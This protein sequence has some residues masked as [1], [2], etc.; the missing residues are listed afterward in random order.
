MP[1]RQSFVIEMVGREDI[2][3]AVALN[4]AIFNAARI[5]GPAV[6]GVAIGIFD[7]GVAFLINGLSFLAVLASLMAMRPAEL[8]PS[9]RVALPA[10]FTPSWPTWPKDSAMSATRRWSCWRSAWSGWCRRPG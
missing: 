6:A 3:N 1:T 5:V 8:R 10:P 9:V 7:I 2:G 4:S